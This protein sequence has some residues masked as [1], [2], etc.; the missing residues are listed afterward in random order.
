MLVEFNY[1]IPNAK[2]VGTGVFII[3]N[4]AVPLYLELVEP[5]ADFPAFKACPKLTAG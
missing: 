4:P 2:V 3:I 5:D 1:D